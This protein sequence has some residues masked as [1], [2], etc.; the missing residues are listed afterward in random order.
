[1]L[2]AQQFFPLFTLEDTF[3][4]SHQYD[5]VFIADETEL[6]LFLMAYLFTAGVK[7]MGYPR[8]KLQISKG[9]KLQ[10]NL[11]K[12]PRSEVVAVGQSSCSSAV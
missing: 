6:I 3:S 1:M 7:L 4:H 5:L 8:K 2:K 12:R 10:N 9:G 11:A